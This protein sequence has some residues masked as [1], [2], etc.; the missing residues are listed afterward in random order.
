ML[1]QP[2][3][4][5]TLPLKTRLLANACHRLS[6]TAPGSIPRRT[7]IVLLA[8]AWG[9]LGY[10]AGVSYLGHV[11]QH[12]ALARGPVLE[13]GSGATTLLMATLMRDSGQRLVVLEHN[14]IWF[15]YM[16]QVLQGLGYDH[17]AL[18]HAPLRQYGYYQWYDV[19]AQSLNGGIAVVVCDGPPGSIP[20]GRYGLMPVMQSSLADDC[21]ILL[22]D[23]HRQAE[24]QI[25]E[26]WRGYRSL[27]ANRVGRFGSHAEVRLEF[28]G[29]SA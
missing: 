7:D 3:R 4:K 14:E 10:A 23:T 13:C 1:M 6:Q 2:L 12:V 16:Q 11:A 22:D 8:L 9:N 15:N 29:S 18:I 20:G 28:T 24:R 21:V 25:I 17:V 19:D 26:A 5:A 27:Q